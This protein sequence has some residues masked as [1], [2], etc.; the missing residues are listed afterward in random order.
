MARLC[1]CNGMSFRHIGAWAFVLVCSMSMLQVRSVVSQEAAVQP[2]RVVSLPEILVPPEVAIPDAGNVEAVIVVQ[3]DGS[4]RA[5]SCEAAEALCALV[6]EALVQA[7]FE[8][9]LREGVAI[10][11][12]IRIALRLARPAVHDELDSDAGPPETADTVS[13]SPLEQQAPPPT[14]A[15]TPTAAAPTESGPAAIER[16]PENEGYGARAQVKQIKQPGMRRLEL[17][18]LRALRT[19]VA[20]RRWCPACPSRSSERGERS[21]AG[22]SSTAVPAPHRRRT[23]TVARPIPVVS[24]ERR[25]SCAP[26]KGVAKDRATP[27]S[28][29]RCSRVTRSSRDVGGRARA[30]D[31]LR[32]L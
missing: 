13:G 3:V 21:N 7:R 25:S 26:T 28:R 8:P 30:E 4:A 15:A 12:R 22:Q 14:A 24:G 20:L 17:A 32:P 2:P 11:A 19:T 18:E 5:E 31:A 29:G 27:P 9:A 23:R 1:D 16:E 6:T 10:P